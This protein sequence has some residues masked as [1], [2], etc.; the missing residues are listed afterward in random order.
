MGLKSTL[1]LLLLFC[2]LNLIINQE[3]LIPSILNETD[4]LIIRSKDPDKF[5]IQPDFGSKDYISIVYTPIEVGKK[6]PA[7]IVASSKENCNSDRLALST[8]YSGPIYIF[9]RRGQVESKSGDDESYFV[10]C[11]ETRESVEFGEYLIE[12]K[13]TNKA[14]LPMGQQTSYFVDDYNTNMEFSLIKQ[15]LSEDPTQMSIW[16]RGKYLSE[17]DTKMT[18]YTKYSYEDGFI[19]F[20]EFDHEDNYLT[21][22]STKGD[23]VTVGSVPYDG[24]YDSMNSLTI[25]GNE[26]TI[27]AERK[28]C[29][30]IDFK[31]QYTYISGKLYS[32]K[33]TTYFADSRKLVIGTTKEITDGIISEYNVIKQLDPTKDKGYYCIESGDIIILTI[34]IYTF[35]NTFLITPPT[36][37]GEIRRYILKEGEK[38]AFT[39]MAYGEHASKENFNMKAIRGFP[40]MYYTTNTKFPDCSFNP[41]RFDHPIVSNR[42]AT[43]LYEVKKQNT[44]IAKSQP[45]IYVDCPEGNKAIGNLYD[46][47]CEFEVT[48]FT[49]NDVV[50][51]IEDRT[52]SQYLDVSEQNDYQIKIPS[53]MRPNKNNKIYIDL[54]I[55]SGDADLKINNFAG[56]YPN[57]YY[58]PNKVFCYIT[59]DQHPT[60]FLKFSVEAKKNTFYM[61]NYLILNQ[62]IYG[63]KNNIDSG[64]NYITL[65]ITE[66]DNLEKSIYLKNTKYEDSQPFMASFYSPNCKFN[67]YWNKNTDSITVPQFDNYANIII[68]NKYTDF[69]QETYHFTY[70]VIR[71]ENTDYSKSFC[72]VAVAG[73][74]LPSKT[75]TG[76]S[77]SL[78]EGVP[79]TFTYSEDYPLANYSYFITDYDKSIV[80][81]LHLLDRGEY[82]VYTYINNVGYN[83]GDRILRSKQLSISG[84]MLNVR[85]DNKVK[86]CKIDINVLLVPFSEK[87]QKKVQIRVYQLDTNPIYLEKNR[88]TSDF[89]N[90]Y[91]PKH[92]YFDITNQELSDITLDF[93]R[94]SGNIYAKIVKTSNPEKEENPDWRGIY[95]FPTGPTDIE[96]S[97]YGKKL[98]ITKDN[99]SGCSNGCYVLLTVVGNMEIPGEF[100]DENLPFRI[101]LNTRVIKSIPNVPIPK[102]NIR[103]NEFIIGDILHDPLDNKKYDYYQIILPYDS[104]EVIID[105]Q[106]DSPAFLINVGNE[107]PTK[108]D[109]DFAYPSFGDFVF[110]IPNKDILKNG[111]S[112]Q[113]DSLEGIPLTIGIYANYSDSIKSSPYAFKIYMPPITK[114]NQKIASQMIHI[115]SDQKVQCIPW[116][117]EKDSHM[118]VFAVIFDELDFK[119]NLVLYPKSNGKTFTKYGKLVKAEIIEK[120]DINQIIDEAEDMMNKNSAEGFTDNDLIYIENV[121]KEDSY[122]LITLFDHEITDDKIEILSSTYAYESGMTFIPNPSTPQIFALN[123]KSIFFQFQTT[124]DLLI[125]LHSLAGIGGFNWQTESEKDKIMFLRGRDDR[126]SLTTTKDKEQELPKLNTTSYTTLDYLKTGFVFYITYYPRSYM[127][128]LKPNSIGEIHYRTVNMPLNYFAHIGY[129]QPWTV[130]LNF[131]DI[132]PKNTKEPL[133]YETDLFTIYGTVVPEMKIHEARYSERLRPKPTP[134]NTFYGQFDSMFG[135]MFISEEDIDRIMNEYEYDKVPYIFFGVNNTDSSIDYETI[136]L[137]ADV[138]SVGV[139]SGEY[140]VPEGIYIT[141][142]LKSVMKGKK[143]YRLKMNKKNDYVR[144]EYSTNSV[145]VKFVLTSDHESETHSE[146]RFFDVQDQSGRKVLTV[147]LKN[148]QME[149][150]LFFVA[151]AAYGDDYEYDDALDYFVFKYLT[152]NNE[153]AFL[154]IDC[155]GLDDKIDFNEDESEHKITISFHPV[156][157]PDV[158]Y[159]IKAIYTEDFVRGENVNSIAMSESKGMNF[160][161]NVPETNENLLTYDIPYNKDVL[162]VKVMAVYGLAEEKLIFLYKP[163]DISENRVQDSISLLKTNKL[164][165]IT[166]NS[167]YRVITAEVS[168]AGEK[169]KYQVKFENP[170]LLLE[171]VKVEVYNEEGENSPMLCFSST[172]PDCMLNRGQISKGGL[173]TTEFY[174]KKGQFSN[175]FFL[176]VQCQT[177]EGCSY[178]ITISKKNEAEID[179]MGVFNYYVSEG[180]RDMNFKFKNENHDEE[181]GQLTL[182]ATGG[183]NIILKLHDCDELDCVQHDFNGGAAITIPSANLEYYGVQV[184]AQAG[185][186]ISLGIDFKKEGAVKE[187]T[188][189]MGETTGLLKKEDLNKVCYDLPDELDVY[190]ITGR[191]FDGKAI[192]KYMDSNNEEVNIKTSKYENGFFYAV[193]NTNFHTVNS[194]CIS[195]DK[196]EIMAYSVQIQAHSTFNGANFLPQTNGFTYPRIIPVGKTITLNSLIPKTETGALVF[197]MIAK[198]GYPKMYTYDC[199]TYPLINVDDKDIENGV[200]KKVSDINGISTI[201]TLA[202][203]DSPIDAE[204]KLVVFKCHESTDNITVEDYQYCELLVTMFGESETI[205][206]INKQPFGQY[207]TPGDINH[208]LIDFSSEEE[209]PTKVFIDFLVVTGDVK[210]TIYDDDTNEEITVAHKYYLSNKIFYSVPVDDSLKKIRIETSSRINSYYLVEYK[211]I[212]SKGGETTINYINS[213]IN[214]LIPIETNQAEET[215]VIESL[216]ITPPEM[217]FSSFYSLNC[218]FEITGQIQDTP[219]NIDTYGSY[220][221]SV[222]TYKENEE[223]HSKTFVA[224]IKE[225]NLIGDDDICMLYVSGLEYYK[226]TSGIR[227]EILISEGVPQKTIFTESLKKIR[228]VFPHADPSKNLT[229]SLNMLVPGKFGFRIFFREKEFNFDK[230]YSQNGIFF[231]K[232]ETI[233]QFCQDYELCSVTIEIENLETFNGE[234]PIIEF[235]MKQELNTPYYV[236][237]RIL[238]KD[239]VTNDAHLFLYTDI[240]KSYSGYATVDF[241]RGS[242]YVYGKIVQK[243]Q[244]IPDENPH[245]RNYRFIKY[246]EEENSL[247]YDFYNK[248]ILFSETDTEKCDNGC[249]LLISVVSSVIKS[250]IREFDFSPFSILI[251]FSPETYYLLGNNKVEILPDEFIIG[252]LYK[253]VLTEEFNIQ[254]YSLICPYDADAIE[255]DWQTNV[256]QLTAEID[257]YSIDFTNNGQ[258]I[259]VISKEMIYGEGQK[260]SKSLK[261]KELKLKVSTRLFET[262][263]FSVYSFR[264]HFRRKEINIHKATSDQKILCKPEKIESGDDS[265]YRCL[266]AVIYKDTELF[267]DLMVYA[268]SQ[269]PSSKLDMY[270]AFIDREIYDGYNV[271]E[272]QKNIPTQGAPF[273]TKATK[274]NFLFIKYGDFDKHVFI[275]IVSNSEKDI[276]IL[277]SFMTL[278]ILLEPNPRSPQ[279]YPMDL[280]KQEIHINFLTKKS[281]AINLMS[282]HGEA[283][284]SLEQD[285]NGPFYLRGDEDNLKYI[286]KSDSERVNTD[287][288]VENLR[289]SDLDY[290]NPGCAFILEFSLR[291]EKEELDSLKIGETTEFG[292][293]DISQKTDIYYYAKVTDTDKDVTAFFYLHDLIY[294]N[295]EIEGRTIKSDEFIFKAKVVSETNIY[296]IKNGKENIPPD[297]YLQGVYDTTLKAGSIYVPKSS[298]NNIQNPVILLTIRKNEKYRLDFLRFRGE[299]GLNYINSDV[300]VI[301]NSYQLGKIEGDKLVN[302]KLKTDSKFSNYVRIQFSANSEYVDFAINQEKDQKINGTFEE[303]EDKR[304]RGITFVTF[305]RPDDANFLYLTIFLTSDS[306]NKDEKE[307]KQ[308]NNYIFKYM[309]GETNSFYEFK[310]VNDNPKFTTSKE[311]GDFIVKFNTINTEEIDMYEPN[312]IYTVK[313]VPKETFIEDEKSD[314]IAITESPA[315]AQQYKHLPDTNEMSVKFK[316]HDVNYTYAQI[317]ATITKG[318]YVEYVTYQAI[319]MDGE[320]IDPSSNPEP[321]PTGEDKSDTTKPSDTD[322]K[323]GGKEP[324]SKAMIAVIV[325]SCFLF[326]VVVVLVVVIVMYNSKNKDLLT[327]VNKISFV[328]S[329]ASAKDDANLLLDNQNELD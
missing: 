29:F 79:H 192:I 167:K 247:E 135:V 138:H 217:F 31:S 172:D 91:H 4:P 74:E 118:C 254:K 246:L 269:D 16:V 293:Q 99:T 100:D 203:P 274:T 235:S 140:Y 55:F 295:P 66:N 160:F 86:V 327:Q 102:V 271:E 237:R 195:L 125:N 7:L 151:F 19:F 229:C 242:G 73:L 265:Y 189:E 319:D 75:L 70:R 179:H 270:G 68:D 180:N 204:Q 155:G 88:V 142:K 159:F 222:Y 209:R 24:E 9:L 207:N 97:A 264:V 258:S 261:D 183:K 225:K 45:I 123:D 233:Q 221:Q 96:Y 107:P 308:L 127:D 260:D 152:A 303:F 137:E 197:N 157:Y 224:K 36:F 150:D 89:L 275:S 328:Q 144:L 69:S 23:Y 64:V 301:Q 154:P 300:P 109:W 162:Y 35:E 1:K 281:L 215:I 37:P 266:L 95:K 187:L 312:V 78:E 42:F 272:L 310:I 279:I 278:E 114:Q 305:K 324:L 26:M 61:V 51:I 289:Y 98:T 267:N 117:Y 201:S 156:T 298:Y 72:M 59:Y 11:T 27:Y 81:D 321:P 83:D 60:E 325:V 292:Y 315:I 32:L 276:E 25:N 134:E 38:A 273:D 318:S 3:P 40:E 161:I 39:G 190:F 18:S 165:N 299:I 131:Y 316:E 313:L 122:L 228:Y 133:L 87:T 52:F 2:S 14:E 253:S 238:R 5:L 149:K 188:P 177:T 10:I 129:M 236:E 113:T 119:N 202:I 232:N 256:V 71:D 8:Q 174:I 193:Y 44:P 53:E 65:K 176:T 43:Y 210:I 80:I 181:N 116:E 226:T 175:S 110:K 290:Q 288:T 105:W 103:L 62:N 255:I 158:S 115:R 297:F 249:F 76:R 47:F 93:N 296:D 126:L 94:G 63:D 182:Y 307:L 200:T 284:I 241:N 67:A 196:Q 34:Q 17:Q 208:Y 184:I 220:S 136:G 268:K 168:E 148:E 323:S 329:G 85:C 239:Y 46:K 128:Q 186:Y 314:L 101:T 132:I 84:S 304:E 311:N 257:G 194:L 317:I 50:K 112:S 231:L 120:N 6:N 28:I 49:E 145:Y 15:Q 243:D 30:P 164:Q 106:A 245:W 219:A 251:D 240:G 216:K 280:L 218:K 121:N 291:I 244:A 163:V 130:N 198:V 191:I 248:K 54:T 169:Q 294:L 259:L 13:L 185:D 104:E 322:K 230:V 22:G 77:I 286:V 124:D 56:G 285:D 320:E 263:G 223:S 252:S 21:V 57:N 173:K 111:Y 90:G 146:F 206:L 139:E 282:L 141:G 41:I 82:Y 309:N 287:L 170:E 171:Y 306:E 326:I 108:D 205:K 143:I 92:Y 12:V 262:H 153:G 33:A 48:I 234:S 214:Y 213:G 212:N 211:L 250:G 147:Q 178:N 283:K 277:T 227:K 199:D 58:L 20:S 166:L 302:Y